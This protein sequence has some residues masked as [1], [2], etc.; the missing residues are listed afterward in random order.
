MI[1]FPKVLYCVEKPMTIISYV[2][3]CVIVVLQVQ[4]MQ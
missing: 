4:V 3:A 2:Y 1:Y